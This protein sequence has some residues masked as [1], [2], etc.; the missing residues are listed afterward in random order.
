MSR[1]FPTV[2]TKKAMMMSSLMAK[3][4]GYPVT[5]CSGL[6]VSYFIFDKAIHTWK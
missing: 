4:P 5:S 6:R 1:R 3:A 2:K